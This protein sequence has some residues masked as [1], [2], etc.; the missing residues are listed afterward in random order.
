MLTT[1]DK[2]DIRRIIAETLRSKSAEFSAEG[3]RAEEI[4]QIQR[5]LNMFAQ[6]RDLIV[7][8]GFTDVTFVNP[9]TGET[10]V[11][12]VKTEARPIVEVTAR[13][14]EVF[15]TRDKAWKWLNTPLRS[16]GDRT[17]IS[18]LS[19]PEGVVQVQD[20]LGRVEHGVW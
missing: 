17:P 7:N 3:G 14:M 6:L 1:E 11:L 2:E 12:E 13:A 20:I 4:E 19:S 18:L 10:T 9:R 15:G 5:L 8:E 16:L